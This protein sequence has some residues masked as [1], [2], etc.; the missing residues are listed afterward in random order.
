MQE[1]TKFAK[2]QG[3]VTSRTSAKE[4]V[5]ISLALIKSKNTV[6]KECAKNAQ[7]PVLGYGALQLSSLLMHHTLAQVPEHFSTIFSC[8]VALFA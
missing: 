6:K 8:N 3:K 1:M 7:I 4:H 2:D 5:T